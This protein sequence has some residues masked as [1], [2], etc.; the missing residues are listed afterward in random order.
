MAV[1][2]ASAFLGRGP[3]AD[4]WFDLALRQVR[5]HNDRGAERALRQRRA[6]IAL[7][8]GDLEFV[9]DEMNRNGPASEK[10]G[11]YSG[12]AWASAFGGW[13]SEWLGDLERSLAL[14]RKA[15]EVARAHEEEWPW[16][17][18]FRADALRN[19]AT[20]LL[21]LGRRDEG[22][23]SLGQAIALYRSIDT[24]GWLPS[25]VLTNLIYNARTLLAVGRENEAKTLLLNL[26]ERVTDTPESDKVSLMP[27]L[28]IALAG[29]EEAM[30]DPEAFR[31]FCRDYKARHPGADRIRLVNWHFEPADPA[32][33]G[34]EEEMQWEDEPA[35]SGWEWV[36]SK[37]RSSFEVAGGALSIKAANG[38]NLWFL[39]TR[40]PRLL[41]PVSGDFAAQVECQA[42]L[43]DRPA[44]GGL[45]VWKDTNNFLVLER[46]GFGQAEVSF[47]GRVGGEDRV[48]G[49]GRLASAAVWL[50]LERRGNILRA[51]CSPDGTSWWGLGDMETALGPEVQAGVYASGW[52]DRS[53]HIGVFPEGSAVR[54]RA[55]RLGHMGSQPADCEPG[56]VAAVT[57]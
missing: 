31:A 29:L 8:R 39:N 53:F 45:A 10:A 54:F 25:H 26:I 15:E 21:G 48:A 43:P 35:A 40:A 4:R 50:R 52:I 1:A 51:L 28:P 47:R 5:A 41:R 22:F 24:T 6:V 19:G 38:D 9:I 13:A 34:R 12:V 7:F 14:S 17:Q 44:L 49:R 32:L 3:E 42:A 33:I 23:D 27:R 36:D 16:F 18:L 37:G 56:G 20:A 55:F 11:D 57:A 46:G 2:E 30:D